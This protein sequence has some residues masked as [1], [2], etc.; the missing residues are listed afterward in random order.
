MNSELCGQPHDSQIFASSPRVSLH[1][2]APSS[3]QPLIRFVSVNV[4]FWAVPVNGVTAGVA[5]VPVFRASLTS[6]CLPGSP[7]LRQVAALPL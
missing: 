7:V 1:P 2:P 4:A 6:Q 5:F 3:K